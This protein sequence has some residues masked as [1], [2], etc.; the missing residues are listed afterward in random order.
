MLLLILSFG[1][2]V[3][4]IVGLLLAPATIAVLLVYYICWG[5]A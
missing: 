3:G 1:K 5:Y 2:M 4:V